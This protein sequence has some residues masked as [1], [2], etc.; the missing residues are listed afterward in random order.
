MILTNINAYEEPNSY[1]HSLIDDFKKGN[2]L[3]FNILI[4]IIKNYSLEIQV[5][6]KITKDFYLN[7]YDTVKKIL[8][9]SEKIYTYS[10]IAINTKEELTTIQKLLLIRIINF[11]NKDNKCIILNET[12]IHIPNSLKLTIYRDLLHYVNNICIKYNY[13]ESK[14][15]IIKYFKLD[16]IVSYILDYV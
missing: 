4:N 7:E 6:N 13:N 11:S 1:M 5:N 16:S 10:I 15:N 9:N 14:K 3:S 8:N 2:N 12:L